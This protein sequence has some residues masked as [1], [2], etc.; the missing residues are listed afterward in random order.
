[1]AKLQPGGR[2]GVLS[3]VSLPRITS[4]PFKE[5]ARRG[6][7]AL[8]LLLIST[9]LVWLDNDAYRDNTAQDGVSFIDAI[10]YSTVTVTTTGYGDI[11]PVATHARLINALVITPLR[12]GFLV[13]LVG[14]TIEVLANEGSR[15]IKDN[16]WRRTMRNHV[17]VIGY[18]TKG[19]S[20]VNTLRRQGQKPDRIVVIDSSAAAVNEANLDGL[21]AFQGDATRRSLLRRAE[22]AKARQVIISLDRDDAAILT[23]LNVRQINP[24]A[25]VIVSVREQ[26][27]VMLVRQSGASS[28]VTSSETVGRLLGLSAIGPELGTIMQDMLTGAEGLEVHQRL[29]EIEEVGKPPSSVLGERV[30]GLIRNGTLRRFY[31]QTATRIE[32][33]DELIVVRR[34]APPASKDVLR[35]VDDDD[36]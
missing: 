11:T 12:I 36:L 22:V 25:G 19:R 29:A 4:S 9:M 17:V 23:T 13:L 30:I 8:I 31:D 1:M 10:Y 14:T 34:A 20:A 2:G 21:A 24:T 33:G 18:G 27:N 3:L 16:L 35:A 6:A 5:L 32:T 28:V 26:D 7:L 15:S